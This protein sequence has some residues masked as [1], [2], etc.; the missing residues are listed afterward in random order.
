MLPADS[1]AGKDADQVFIFDADEDCA[2]AAAFTLP[3]PASSRG[4]Q[5]RTRASHVTD[6]GLCNICERRACKLRKKQCGI[7][8]ADIAA[9]RREAE[10]AGKSAL[11]REMQRAGGP[12]FQDFIFNFVK[13]NP[14]RRKYE[15]R[16]CFDFVRYE[17]AYRV[18][19]A[20]RLGFKALMMDREDFIEHHASKGI[21]RSACLQLWDEEVARA[22]RR[23]NNGRQGSLRIPVKVEDFIIGYQG[24]EAETSVVNGFKQSRHTEELEIEMKEAAMHTPG[25]KDE[26]FQ[27]FGVGDLAAGGIFDGVFNAETSFVG[28]TAVGD[29]SVVS[30]SDDEDKQKMSS[31]KRKRAYD[32]DGER[33]SA[34]VACQQL[35]KKNCSDLQ[36]TLAEARECHAEVEQDVD[37]KTKL[38]ELHTILRRR[39]KAVELTLGRRTYNELEACRPE[40]L[41][42]LY[43]GEEEV[44]AKQIAEWIAN[45][46]TLPFPE[47]ATLGTLSKMRQLAVNVGDSATN[48]LELKQAIA[49][50][51]Q[52]TSYFAGLK[53]SLRAAVVKVKAAKK[54]YE[55]LAQTEKASK[56]LELK[57]EIEREKKAREVE[58]RRLAKTFEKIG[59]V[60]SVFDIDFAKV[61]VPPM[62]AAPKMLCLSEVRLC[63]SWNGSVVG[64]LLWAD[65]S[66]IVG[67]VAGRA[68]RGRAFRLVGVP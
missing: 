58:E 31:S 8:C 12:T 32:L 9:A 15:H 13:S 40:E 26:R 11:F 30:R 7:C 20:L 67:L 48:A 43:T 51:K 5:K 35:L 16:R 45:G 65:I 50:F 33:S 3:A 14:E 47:F 54:A 42:T 62:E 4:G 64:Q 24:V 52:K 1:S 60:A 27:G 25:F 63:R 19:T 41:V 68:G 44:L 66:C 22:K 39:I 18:Q 56:D 53:A 21:Q 29:S 6:D 37:I 38:K 10:K 34:R 17:Q 55:K 23:D 57:K 36:P 59:K 46:D 61:G 2:E 49:E 28:G